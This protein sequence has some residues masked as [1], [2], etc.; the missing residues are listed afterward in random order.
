MGEIQKPVI[1]TK[2]LLTSGFLLFMLNG[3]FLGICDYVYFMVSA[4]CQQADTLL[5]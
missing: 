3:D 4:G 1:P 2:S 5:S